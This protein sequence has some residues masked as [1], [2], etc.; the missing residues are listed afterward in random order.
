[1]FFGYDPEKIK[2]ELT[3][4][5]D[6]DDFW[7]ERKRELKDVDPGFKVTRTERSSDDLDVYLVEMR[8]HGDVRIRGWYTVPTRPG[9]HP[10]I[11]S[12]PGYNSTMWPNMRRRNVLRLKIYITLHL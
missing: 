10:A 2:P 7:D 5:D 3:C 1:M 8:S 6:F 9:P 11:L 12:V 4:E